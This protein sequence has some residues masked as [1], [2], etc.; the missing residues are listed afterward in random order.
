MPWFKVEYTPHICTVMVEAI[1]AN[2]AARQIEERNFLS[3]YDKKI[4]DHIKINSVLKM[5]VQ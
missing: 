1:D 3:A 2:D 4:D 5:G